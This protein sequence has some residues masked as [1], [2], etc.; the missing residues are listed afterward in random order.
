MPASRPTLFAPHLPSCL[1]SSLFIGG[2]AD[3]APSFRPPSS[4]N[5]R[6]VRKAKPPRGPIFSKANLP[7]A[8]PRV[9][10]FARHPLDSGS[11]EVQ[12]ASITARTAHLTAHL[13]KMPKD[14]VCRRGL[15]ALVNRRRRLLNYLCGDKPQKYVQILK[16]LSLRHKDP[17]RILTRV[18]KYAKFKNTKATPKTKRRKKVPRTMFTLGG[19]SEPGKGVKKMRVLL[20]SKRSPGINSEEHGLTI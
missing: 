17:N 5:P 11:P 2:G 14:L 1:H 20:A 18:E 8:A 13:A 4:G 16:D 10:A 7:T 3:S 6:K 9:L 19:V 12:V 15:V